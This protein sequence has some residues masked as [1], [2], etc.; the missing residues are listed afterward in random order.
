MS[1]RSGVM[2]LMAVVCGLGA[3]YGANRML[4]KGG[5]APE[6]RDLVVAARDLPSEE[7]LKP[8]AL[9]VIQVPVA[10]APAGAFAKVAEVEGRWVQIKMLADEPIM[11]AKLAPKNAPPGLVSKI[12]NGMR[13]YS[14]EVN[15]QTGVAGFVMPG[16]QVDVVQALTDGPIRPN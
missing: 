11:A 12:P 2:L 13:A 15:E 4:S 6:M 10:G 1:G 5:K 8:E 3:M 9:K 7:V 16:H 14:I